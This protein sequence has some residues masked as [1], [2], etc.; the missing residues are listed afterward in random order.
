MLFTRL[1]VWAVIEQQ[2]A[3][4]LTN[5]AGMFNV[6]AT[7]PIQC[8]HFD[9]LPSPFWQQLRHSA[10]DCCRLRL[11]RIAALALTGFRQVP[12]WALAIA[13]P[14]TAKTISFA[15]L[16]TTTPAGA[17]AFAMDPGG[18]AADLWTGALI[19]SRA[20]NQAASPLKDLTAAKSN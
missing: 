2:P 14:S 19:T 13:S 10:L 20:T 7:G 5:Q 18:Q 8:F 12:C 3:D 9:P 17:V 4:V 15:P 11:L 6:E 1:Q 16:A